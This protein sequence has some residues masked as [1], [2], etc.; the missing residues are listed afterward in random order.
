[1][2]LSLNR[3]GDR[4]WLTKP[5]Q[6]PKQA[7]APSSIR[8][9]PCLVGPKQSRLSAGSKHSPELWPSVF[10][11]DK[12]KAP[13]HGFATA[14]VTDVGMGCRCAVDRGRSDRLWPR[15]KVWLEEMLCVKQWEGTECPHSLFRLNWAQDCCHFCKNECSNKRRISHKELLGP[16]LTPRW[17]PKNS[18]Q[19]CF[20]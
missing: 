2:H 20:H 6:N 15:R 16:S 4:R 13:G 17:R 5:R 18:T 3:Q 8:R 7:S 10:H 9:L 14:A 12:N 11:P 1:M 19:P